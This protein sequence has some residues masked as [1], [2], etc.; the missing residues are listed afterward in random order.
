MLALGAPLLAVVVAL[1]GLSILRDRAAVL[2]LVEDRT[3]STVDLVVAHGEAALEDPN[4]VLSAL[5]GPVRAWDL[6]DPVEGRRIYE[7]LRPL[8]DGSPQ[9]YAV[10]ILDGK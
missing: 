8:L 9:I 4:K 7:Q 1:T 10:W 5:D 3:R 6:T 2:R